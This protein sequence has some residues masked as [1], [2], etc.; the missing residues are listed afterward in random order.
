M[1]QAAHFVGSPCEQAHGSAALRA[2][3]AAGSP[4][5]GCLDSSQGCLGRSQGCL[6]SSQGCLG[7]SQGCLGSSQGPL[8]SSQGC[9]GSSQGCLD[10]AVSA[11]P[12][13]PR[14]LPGM[15]HAASKMWFYPRHLE[16]FE[17]SLLAHS[18]CFIRWPS[19]SNTSDL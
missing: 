5:Q 13:V 7:G 18:D 16:S 2:V 11:A 4:S 17:L 8:G 14:Q 19:R 12:G 15:P 9:L 10:G 1:H 6:G 3:S